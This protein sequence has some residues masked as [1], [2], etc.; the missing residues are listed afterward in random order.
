[1]KNKVINNG[2]RRLI[3]IA[4]IKKKTVIAAITLLILSALASFLPYI[5][6]YCI[7][8]EILKTFSSTLVALNTEKIYKFVWLL[9]IGGVINILSYFAALCLLHKAAFEA[10]YKMKIDVLKHFTRL[11]LGFS[12]RM[13]S[14]N[15]RKILDEDIGNTEEFLAHQF[16]DLIY[17]LASCV[18]T[19]IILI[20]VDWRYGAVCL[21][22]I[23]IG[24][25]ILGLAFR[26]D[27]AKKHMQDVFKANA[28][29]NNLAVEYVRGISVLKLFN[30]TLVTFEKF[31]DVIKRYT[32][33]AIEYTL[34][35]EKTI[36]AYTVL[37]HNIYLF[38][39]PIIIFLG[40]STND[41][42]VFASKTVFYIVVAPAITVTMLKIV[43]LVS[44]TFQ[45]QYGIHNMDKVLQ[46]PI[47]KQVSSAKEILIN[48]YDIEFKNVTFNYDNNNKTPA[49]N[50]ISFIS[51]SNKVTAIVG[52]S[53]SGKTTI[54]HLIPR[55]YDVQY[56]KIMIGGIDIR[57]IDL[58]KL[59]T[60]VGFVFQ[61]DYLFKKSIRDNIGMGRE[62]ATDDEIITA[63]KSAY[64]HEFI[65]KLPQGYDTIIGSKN[66]HLSGGE[67]QRISIARAILQDS[68][69]IILDEATA[70]NDA[71]NEYLIQKSF[72]KLL[73]NKTVIM[74][75]HRLNTV[76]NADQIIV[77][78]KGKIV[79]VGVHNDLIENKEIYYSMWETYSQAQLW[80]IGGK[81]NE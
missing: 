54:A 40:R 67:R 25:Y 53:G 8:S 80:R 69:I 63:A 19:I 46:E 42:N 47:I 43:H 73:E 62:G 9:I 12:I 17:T 71:E 15:I 78:D 27:S 77:M 18:I 34:K 60:L 64:C 2:L 50:N 24:I 68:P 81:E 23:G 26:T 41:Y 35:L 75:A 49:L 37:I 20:C 70:F 38:M 48:S 65:T 51:K 58:N 6:I 3:E 72:N 21:V 45:I 14:G 44:K 36:A 56:G 66:V 52:A 5:S 28:E 29:M 32:K 76:K 30:T 1:M 79:E 11:P 59:M 31:Y 10:I 16:P 61:D 22:T 4:T 74:I 7:A 13:G 55:F 57:H 39:L 33:S